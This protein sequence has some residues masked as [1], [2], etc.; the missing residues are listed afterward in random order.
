MD[1]LS[2]AVDLVDEREVEMEAFDSLSVKHSDFGLVFLK[3][4][5]FD[6]IREPHSQPMIA[7]INMSIQT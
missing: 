7:E 5:V 1:V 3:L 2:L 6:H 4:H